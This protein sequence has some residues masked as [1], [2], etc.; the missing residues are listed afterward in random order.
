MQYYRCEYIELYLFY[1]ITFFHCSNKC[2]IVSQVTKNDEI[3]NIIDI[4]GLKFNVVY[5]ETNIKTLRYGHLMIMA[6]QVSFIV[7]LYIVICRISPLETK[8]NYPAINTFTI[9]IMMDLISK[10]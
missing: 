3:K 6:D 4:L 1:F 9:R 8:I 5:D 7:E 10:V 2:T